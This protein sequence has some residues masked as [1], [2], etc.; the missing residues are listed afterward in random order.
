MAT[1]IKLL[2]V[3]I[4]SSS[5]LWTQTNPYPHT[6]ADT[7]IE[8]GMKMMQDSSMHANMMKM[9]MKKMRKDKMEPMK[10]DSTFSTKNEM[11]GDK[12]AVESM[13]MM[14]DM[15]EQMDRDNKQKKN[16]ES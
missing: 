13:K 16:H 5:F 10:T 9:C 6:K 3:I 2:T 15:K 14:C 4:L 7:A 12:M 11:M 1:M 8:Q